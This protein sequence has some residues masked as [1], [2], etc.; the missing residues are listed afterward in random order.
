[1]CAAEQQTGRLSELFLLKRKNTAISNPA[2]IGEYSFQK[3]ILF[4]TISFNLFVS[5]GANLLVIQLM[6]SHRQF[7]TEV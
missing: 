3:D 1:M 7:Y 5:L 6:L 4:H 2:K